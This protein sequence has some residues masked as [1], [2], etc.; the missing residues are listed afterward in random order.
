MQ[1]RASLLAFILALAGSWP[2]PVLA[3]TQQPLT[4]RILTP[5]PKTDPAAAFLVDRGL[6]LVEGRIAASGNPI[7]IVWQ[8]ATATEAGEVVT[9]VQTG[10]ADIGL[11]DPLVAGDR[12]SI[13]QFAYRAPFNNAGSSAM[14]GILRATID[15]I[16]EIRQAFLNADQV[17]LAFAALD[18]YVLVTGKQVASLD[19]LRRKPV[20][21]SELTS[22][23]FP[24]DGPKPVYGSVSEH[25]AALQAGK[26]D[27]LV[28][29]LSGFRA[30]EMKLAGLQ[31][32][33]PGFGAF[34]RVVLTIHKEKWDK[35]PSKLRAAMASAF[36]DLELPLAES[37]QAARKQALADLVRRGAVSSVLA[38]GAR[39]NWAAS[40]PNRVEE[41]TQDAARA[42]LPGKQIMAAYLEALHAVATPTRDWRK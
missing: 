30:T 37:M 23:W 10:S 24:K 21:V 20:G 25:L 35:L 19:D 39:S 22:V 28:A 13:L 18:D 2:F 41:W 12:L 26:L 17:L 11:Y 36:L 3:Q 5:E 27:A 9:S 8:R 16:P 1:L 31:V 32:M 29:R 34:P 42:G 7:R 14:R 40:L 4:L 38:P 15:R 33:E 6:T